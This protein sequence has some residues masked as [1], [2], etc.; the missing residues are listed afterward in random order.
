[1]TRKL[2]FVAVQRHWNYGRGKDKQRLLKKPDECI[3]EH[4]R[5]FLRVESE[6]RR[7][8]EVVAHEV[9]FFNSSLRHDALDPAQWLYLIRRH[10]AVENNCHHTFDVAFEE[11]DRPWITGDAQ[12]MLSVLLLRRIA[13][14][15]LTLFRSVTQRS[16]EARAIPW[17][18]LL[19]WVHTT[20]VGAQQDDIA[21]LRPRSH[22]LALG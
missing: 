8:D 10:W 20:L 6:T 15:L 13:Y 18:R 19:R 17:K 1:M 11:D 7:G 5:T 4:T 14:T 12:G 3:W 9:R 21:G 22:A 16:D 2:S